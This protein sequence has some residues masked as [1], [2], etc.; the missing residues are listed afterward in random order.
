V[1]WE[2]TGSVNKF[3]NGGATEKFVG[4]FKYALVPESNFEPTP[5]YVVNLE[6]LKQA[7]DFILNSDEWKKVKEYQILGDKKIFFMKRI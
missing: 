5:F 3:E 1:I 4:N 2:S 7:R 6:G